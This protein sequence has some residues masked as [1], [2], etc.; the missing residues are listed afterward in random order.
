MDKVRWGVLGV[1]KIAVERVIPATQASALA[2]VVAIA[3]RSLD[4]ARGAAERLGIPRAYGSYEELLADRDLEAIY[5][6]LPNHLHVPWAI[7]ALDAG[8]HVLCEKPIAL[9]ASE[10]RSLID[11]RQ[12]SGRL[13]QEAAM[14]KTHPRWLGARA[15]VR[16]GRIGELRAIAGFFSYS[17]L[18]PE[19]VRN[20]ADIGGGGLMD[21]GF[22]PITIARF[23]FEAEPLRVIGLLERDPKF[24][25]DRL[26]SALLEFPGGQAI[27][28]CAT[29]LVPHQALDVFGTRGRIGV[30]IP[31]GMPADRPSRLI[32]D[33]G[34]SLTKDRLESVEFPA[35][36]QWQI[37]CHRFCE[38]IRAGSAAPIPIED[39][40]LNMQVIDAL[41]RSEASNRW[42]FPAQS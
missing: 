40:V 22:Y 18:S 14:V 30:E 35:C 9:S 19:N 21:I 42:E 28:T 34:S 2:E 5:I 32:I 16:A 39:A 23:L 37:Q 26:T 8:K 1:A 24:G 11:A 15:L 41:V 25:T 20:R 4:K 27:F 17:N 29:Q 36:D 31:W 6:P 13:I 7:R 33:D 3:S 38:A 10:A 12:R